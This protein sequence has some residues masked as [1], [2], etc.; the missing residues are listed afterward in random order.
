MGLS[1]YTAFHG[2]F[3]LPASTLV[4]EGHH[5]AETRLAVIL[6]RYLFKQF[7]YIVGRRASRTRI[8]GGV[9]TRRP[10]ERIHKKTGVVGKTIIAVFLLYIGGLLPGISLYRVAGL[11]QLFSTVYIGKRKDLNPLAGKLTRLTQ[12]VGIVGGKYY[13][14]SYLTRSQSLLL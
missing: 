5:C 3:K 7:H 11:R 6:I 8:S 14:H 4:A 2:A 9:Y 13:F 10:G 1:R 12:F